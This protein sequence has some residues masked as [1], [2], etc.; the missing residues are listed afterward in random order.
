M[1]AEGKYDLKLASHGSSAGNNLKE[2]RDIPGSPAPPPSIANPRPSR[3]LNTR[4]S[5]STPSLPD[6]TDNQV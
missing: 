1:G 3:H 6:A 4:K 5:L 2:E